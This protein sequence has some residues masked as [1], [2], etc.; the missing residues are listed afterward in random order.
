MVKEAPLWYYIL[1]ESEVWNN[2]NSVGPTGSY[3]IA[4]TIHAA[5]R[6]D[7]DSYLKHK[8][9]N[10]RSPLWQFADG[11]RPIRGLGELFREAAGF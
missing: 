3:I 2:G 1:K 9:T 11:Y 6:Y 7:K 4:E 8:A 10:G 5:L